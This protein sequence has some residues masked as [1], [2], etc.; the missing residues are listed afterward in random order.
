[1]KTEFDNTE[2]EALNKTDVSKSALIN[3]KN[4][5]KSKSKTN[6]L[7]FLS[8]HRHSIQY[9]THESMIIGIHINNSEY[10][11]EK[12]WNGKM[13]IL[14]DAVYNGF[15]YRLGLDSFNSERSLVIRCNNFAKY[16]LNDNVV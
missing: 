16:I 6:G 13:D 10:V 7:C 15:H 8:T 5:R 2:N 1:M 11:E 4:V 14:L 3:V 12:F 9:Y